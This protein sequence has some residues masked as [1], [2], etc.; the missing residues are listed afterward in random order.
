MQEATHAFGL[1]K[2]PDVSVPR[3]ALEC[4]SLGSM[5]MAQNPDAKPAEIS[6]TSRLL[7]H[8]ASVLVTVIEHG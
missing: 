3:N 4:T 8:T 2:A 7:I 6:F 5:I 1:A